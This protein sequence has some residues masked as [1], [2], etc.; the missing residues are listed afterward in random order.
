MDIKDWN[1][2]SLGPS[3]TIGPLLCGSAPPAGAMILAPS[4]QMMARKRDS[5][6][7]TGPQ[8]NRAPTHQS[9]VI[10]EDVDDVIKILYLFCKKTIQPMD[11][12]STIG[13]DLD[14]EAPPPAK[15]AKINNTNGQSIPVPNTENSTNGGS[16]RQFFPTPPLPAH[17]PIVVPNP[18][19]YL[20]PGLLFGVLTG[21]YRIIP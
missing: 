5:G 7:L 12:N 13:G 19:P 18:Q 8:E 11:F 3:S 17:G 10:D 4:G 2:C 6:P 14:S 20:W 9:L 1:I 15:K 16:T 21:M